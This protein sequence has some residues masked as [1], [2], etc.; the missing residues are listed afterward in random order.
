MIIGSSTNSSATRLFKVA[1][2]LSGVFTAVELTENGV[3]TAGLSSIPVGILAEFDDETATV[4]V[5]GGTFWQVGGQSIVA[6]DLL[7]SDD[8]GRATKATSGQFA[9]ALA[10]ENASASSTAEI[11]IVNAGIAR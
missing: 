3:K 1:D 6:G 8:G 9:F 7:A 5:S 2:T 4:N 10:L 11:Q